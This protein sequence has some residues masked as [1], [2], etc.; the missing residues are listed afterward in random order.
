MSGG[1]GN[2]SGFE[3]ELQSF[4]AG[5]KSGAKADADFSS[6]VMASVRDWER[7]KLKEGVAERGLRAKQ[8]GPG[9]GL[10]W[11]PGFLFPF[12]R[13]QPVLG[14]AFSF[15]LLLSVSGLVYLGVGPLGKPDAPDITRIKG[16]GFRLGFLL[17]REGSLAPA[18]PG[19]EFLPGDL[20]QAVYSAPARGRFHLFS[21]DAGGD[22][23]CFSCASVDT[24]LPAGQDRPLS[25]ALELDASPK[26]EVFAG[27]WSET[28]VSSG[29]VSAMLS[30]AWKAAGHD[31]A[32]LP[33]ALRPRLSRGLEVSI[34]PIRKKEST[35]HGIQ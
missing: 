17:K 6:R 24:W 33:E 19:M 3:K 9:P 11:F 29:E 15:L 26:R 10:S 23:L 14:M 32:K 20:L 27:F 34:F 28:P 2:D 16:E 1:G 4:L 13:R 18:V 21:L 8:P 35:R 25:Y 30:A 22:I 31:L 12:G 5:R 7:E